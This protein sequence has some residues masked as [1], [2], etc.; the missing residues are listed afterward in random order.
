[1]LQWFETL[2]GPAYAS[3]LMWTFLA[4]IALLVLLIGIRIIRSVTFGTFVA[5]GRNRK[6][7]LAVM[8]ATA[9]DSHRRLVLVRRDDV[10]HLI[11]I[12]G[13][14]D[15]VVEQN[16]RL[17]Q[18]ARRQPPAQ[19][20]IE[21]Q[22]PK[23]A[24]PVPVHSEE[25][26]PETPPV[27]PANGGA[28][29]QPLPPPPAPSVQ[30]RAEPQREPVFEP[31]P[32]EPQPAQAR[33]AEQAAQAMRQPTAAAA[34]EQR[35]EPSRPPYPAQPAAAASAMPS[36]AQGRHS[37]DPVLSIPTYGGA[38]AA[39]SARVDSVEPSPQQPAPHHSRDAE[40]DEALLEE[41]E[42]TLDET[43][44]QDPRREPDPLDDEMA[45]LLG[46]LSGH[47]N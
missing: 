40:L 7:R 24:T 38:A 4:L 44:R 5:G 32:A 39:S 12:G 31:R 23:A 36:P 1:M 41:L 35:Q 33:P 20:E 9:V 2:A 18:P 34:Q 10:E 14:T 15:V 16:I 42:F 37:Q 45:K 29:H 19:E 26:A 46:E 27:R 25:A 8:D 21:P 28:A 22:A 17:L 43:P 3:A 6:A 11:L 13:P 30:T 47:K